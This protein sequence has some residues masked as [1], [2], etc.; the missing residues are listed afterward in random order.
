MPKRKFTRVELE[1]LQL[2]H[3]LDFYINPTIQELSSPFAFPRSKERITAD[4]AAIAIERQKQA[5]ALA[6]LK[7]LEPQFLIDQARR[8]AKDLEEIQDEAEDDE[9]AI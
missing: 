3:E 2:A 9:P 5:K 7:A 6:R 8:H 1:Y 4:E